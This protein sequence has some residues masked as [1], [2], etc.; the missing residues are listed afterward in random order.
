[1]VIQ[2]RPNGIGDLSAGRDWRTGRIKYKSYKWHKLT[3]NRNKYKCSNNYGNSGSY[4]L[5]QY[6]KFPSESE[7]PKP[8]YYQS[9]SFENM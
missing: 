2:D 7:L 9:Y 5:D 3:G 8:T 1:M 6:L 4:V